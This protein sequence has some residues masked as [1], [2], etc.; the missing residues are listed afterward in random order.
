MALKVQE[1]IFYKVHYLYVKI[2]KYNYPIIV[3]RSN[4]S[5]CVFLK[6]F[7]NNVMSLSFSVVNTKTWQNCFTQFFNGIISPTTDERE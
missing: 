1:N 5:N 4:N 6:E 2:D 3:L 7:I